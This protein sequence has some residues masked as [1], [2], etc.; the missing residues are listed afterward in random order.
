M[1]PVNV[2]DVGVSHTLL[3]WL[4]RLSP[5][6]FEAAGTRWEGRASCGKGEEIVLRDAAPAR[7][8]RVGRS[9]ILA[10]I[11]SSDLNTNAEELPVNNV[12]A[13]Q[14]GAVTIFIKQVSEADIA[15]FE[16]V[17]RPELGQHE[18]PAA[19]VRQPRKA[20][21]YPL[22]V[23][24]LSAA[25]A[26]HTPRPELARFVRQDVHYSAPIY[27]DD[28]L[29]V[30]AELVEY[31]AAAHTLRIHAHCRNQDGLDLADG[32]LLLMDE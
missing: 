22:L 32:E 23:A 14:V 24:L 25:A 20:A 28:V 15:L 31:D 8:P 12:L 27:T 10:V 11:I 7:L 17:T 18:E 5:V 9:A 2:W 6:V 19:P 3:F 21:P 30:T 4:G 1:T 16:L 29:T 26:Y 13:R